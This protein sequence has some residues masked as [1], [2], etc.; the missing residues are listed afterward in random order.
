[1]FVDDEKWIIDLNENMISYKLRECLV[2][3]IQ[4]V[5]LEVW[6]ESYISPSSISL[7]KTV[8]ATFV[9]F[10]LNVKKLK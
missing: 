5:L 7:I 2:F 3:K 4:N 8:H 6:G 1:M 9:K 10:D